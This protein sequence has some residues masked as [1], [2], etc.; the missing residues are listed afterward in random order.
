M[1]DD[2]ILA[3]PGGQEGNVIALYVLYARGSTRRTNPL[4][5]PTIARL[6]C[7]AWALNAPIFWHLLPLFG[8]P[9]LF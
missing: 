8:L 7:V 1:N 3:F 2:I 5:A 6:Q 4:P 9:S